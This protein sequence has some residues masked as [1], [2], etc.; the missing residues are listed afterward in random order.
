MSAVEELSKA[1]QEVAERV[2]GSVVGVGRAGSGVVVSDGLVATNAHNLREGSV[3][4]V[5]ADGREAE[6]TVAAVDPDGDVA[7]LHV[8]TGG[9]PAV[10][11]A[12]G[13]LPPL[14]AV[15]FGVARPGERAL[16]TTFGTGSAGG[17]ALPGPP[18]RRVAG[19]LPATPPPGRGTCRG[20]PGA[21]PGKGPPP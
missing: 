21:P 10:S 16:R 17:S 8:D 4:V 2:G 12:G 6:G 19:R 7:V 15:V 20:P 11:W 5:F 3:A 13:E 14:G 18:G 1:V 9:A